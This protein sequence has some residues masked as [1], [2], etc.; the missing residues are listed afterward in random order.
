[1]YQGTIRRGDWIYNMKNQ[2]KVKVPRL[3]RM[4]SNE[5]E[6]SQVAQSL[7]PGHEHVILYQRP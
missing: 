7:P 6:V 5:M 3:V 2:R 4:H 1:V